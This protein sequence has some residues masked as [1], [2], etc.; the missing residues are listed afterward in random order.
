MAKFPGNRGKR[1]KKKAV[2]GRVLVNFGVGPGNRHPPDDNSGLSLKAGHGG[3]DL[4]KKKALARRLALDGYDDDVIA[5]IAGVSRETLDYWN[6]IHPDL[7]DAIETGRTAAD[8]E[9][10]SSLFQLSVGYTKTVEEV[11][12]KDADRIRYKKYYPPELGAI[13]TWLRMRGNKRFKEAPAEIDL[14]SKGKRLSSDLPKET[15]QDIINS[16]VAAV[17]PK[18]D[19]APAPTKKKGK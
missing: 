4:T 14:T 10:V 5:R 19:N 17:R 3:I 6:A 2:K 7:K 16:I 13:K 9:V 11:H 8:A 12:G 18:P 15:R 1:A